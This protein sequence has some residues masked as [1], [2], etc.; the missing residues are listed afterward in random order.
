MPPGD[1]C[2]YCSCYPIFCSYPL[3]LLLGPDYY[4]FS[5]YHIWSFIK[6]FIQVPEGIINVIYHILLKS[7]NSAILFQILPG[8]AKVRHLLKTIIRGNLNFVLRPCIKE[9]I[10]NF[11]K[12]PSLTLEEWDR[13]PSFVLT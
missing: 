4:I 1:K 7:H 10:L 13:G 12:I 8:K 2:H 5:R 6:M 3:P 9:I 11:F